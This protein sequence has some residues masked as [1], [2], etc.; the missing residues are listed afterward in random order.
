M[1]F[2]GGPTQAAALAC[3][4]M[5]EACAARG[6]ESIGAGRRYS[7]LERRTPPDAEVLGALHDQA[8]GWLDDNGRRRGTNIVETIFWLKNRRGW[9]NE[10]PSAGDEPAKGG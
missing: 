4:A 10:P 8:V 1:Y 9:R 2:A 6:V 7:V 5:G 3:L